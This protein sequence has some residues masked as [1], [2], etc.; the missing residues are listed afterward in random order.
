MFLVHLVQHFLIKKFNKRDKFVLTQ[1]C[2][3]LVHLVQRFL[4]V[5]FNNNFK[6]SKIYNKKI[7]KKKL[8][9]IFNFFFSKYMHCFPKV[10]R[11]CSCKTFWST[12]LVLLFVRACCWYVP[13]HFTIKQ[14]YQKALAISASLCC[15]QKYASSTP[16]SEWLLKHWWRVVTPPNFNDIISVQPHIFT[17]IGLAWVCIFYT[18][19]QTK[20]K[21][22]KLL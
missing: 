14:W 3:F 4:I 16:P 7:K 5:K 17:Q 8:K 6:K 21:E 15:H 12:F 11:N 22:E 18:H 10:H 1:T 20:F 9:K 2:M 13:P 19:F